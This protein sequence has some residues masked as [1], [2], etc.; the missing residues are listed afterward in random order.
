M[1]RGI[2]SASAVLATAAIGVLAGAGYLLVAT[3]TTGLI[4]LALE[5]RYLPL[6]SYLDSRRY[7]DRFR[8]DDAPPGARRWGRAGPPGPAKSTE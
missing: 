8:D 3:V 1:V 6:L 4:L 2:T 7:L 5:I